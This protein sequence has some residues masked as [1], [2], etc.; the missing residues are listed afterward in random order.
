MFRHACAAF[1]AFSTLVAST[2]AMAATYTNAANVNVQLTIGQ[3]GVASD[4]CSISTSGSVSFANNQASDATAPLQVGTPTAVVTCNYSFP[5]EITASSAPGFKMT[6]A[7][8]AAIP[9]T[10]K[11]SS[12]TPG[13]GGYGPDTVLSTAGAKLNG[14]NSAG[15]LTQTYRINSTITSWGSALWGSNLPPVG[16]VFSDTVTLTLAF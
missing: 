1:A 11:L 8:Y 10:F 16:T 3:P 5:Y 12:G 14:G 13:T 6:N 9:Y 7:T 15:N 2:G 4:S